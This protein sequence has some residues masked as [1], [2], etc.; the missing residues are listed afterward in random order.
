M[1][2][3]ESM[4]RRTFLV[5]NYL[6]LSLTGILCVLPFINLLAIS[7]SSQ[8]AVSSGQV[9]FLPVGFT[10]SSYKFI[11]KSPVFINAF[12]VSIERVV[13]GLLVNMA[14]IVMTAYPL[15][16]DKEKFRM[17]NVYSWFFVITI[18]FNAG[19]IPTYMVVKYTGFLDSIWS[20]ILPG[21]LPVFSMLVAMNFF[22]TLP[23][24]LE[25]AAFIDGA[26]HM[27]TLFKIILPV[28]KPVLATVGL[29]CL[30]GHWNSWFD[31]LLYMDRQE[32]YPLQSYL[33]TVII[34][35]E[36]FFRNTKNVSSDIDNLLGFINVRTTKAAQLFIA[37]LPVLIAYPFLQKYFTT[38]LVLGSVKG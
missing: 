10:L 2:R 29:F 26:S 20:L 24:E 16:K 37:T 38:G 31:G 5:S 12:M 21:A 17:R 35:P 14:L 32:H 36:V 11:A 4:G 9:T 13:L 15:S 19:M 3:K 8:T 30:V 6:F 18:L 22:R 34:N 23:K 28:S 27:T 25:E 7:F 1:K 33:Q